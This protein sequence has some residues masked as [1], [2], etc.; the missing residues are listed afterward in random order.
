MPQ[1]NGVWTLSAAAQAQTTQQWVTDPNFKN[2]TLL[3]QADNASNAAQNNTFLDFSNNSFPIT[4]FGNAT[5]GTFTPFV[6][7]SGYWSNFF[8]GS[9]TSL[10]MAANS[11]FD[12]NA[13]SFSIE[14]WVY[15]AAIQ[16]TTGLYIYGA[17]S[18]VGLLMLAYGYTTG[19]FKI[20]QG[21]GGGI[22][23]TSANNYPANAW[24]HVA[25]TY[26]GS[27]LKLFINGVLQ[28]SAANAALSARIAGP[29]VAI[30][31]FGASSYFNGYVSNFRIC[32]AAIPTEY[33]TA[34]TTVGTVVFRPST[35]PLTTTSQGASNV[36]FLTCQ[37]RRFIDNSSSQIAIT[38]NG[39]P[40]IQAFG[41]FAPQ[42]QWTPAVIGGS[43]YFDYSG[44]SY[45]RV[46]ASA[47]SYYSA[48]GDW[49]WEAWVYP[50]SFNGP[51]YSCGILHSALESVMLRALPNGTANSTNL[52]MYAINAAGAAIIGASGTSGGTLRIN[53]WAHVVLQ[54]RSGQFDMFLNG[55]R[56]ANNNTQTTQSLRTTDTFLQIGAGIGGT[57]PFWNGYISGVRLQNGT[58]AYPNTTYTIPTAPPNPTGAAVCVNF[59]NAGI[60]DGTMNNVLQ[61]V[62]NAQVSTSVVK[63]GSNSMLFDGTDD[64]VS[65]PS[66][67]SLDLGSGDFTIECWAFNNN[68]DT[69][70]NQLFER[71]RFTVGK[72]YRAWMKPGQIVFEVNLSG[73]AT[74]AYTT[75][76]ATIKNN[77]FQWYHLAFVRNGSNFS[78][79][80]DG[81]QVATATSTAAVF[82]TTEALSVGG[83]ADGNN[84]IMMM[85]YIDD[86]RIT[87]GVARYFGTSFTPPQ[88][89]LPRQ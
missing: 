8:S 59:T 53:E 30:G 41:V 19:Q 43:G 61:T 24:Y 36:T 84:N 17:Q 65:I 70:Q 74:G 15:P 55:T 77:V 45:I 34:S 60:Y 72:S 5:Q 2:T 12:Q 88:V 79:Y 68:W 50:L 21:A 71:G 49:T 51:Q 35:A 40:S 22:R 69:D 28:G 3:L 48:L 80:R 66:S 4:R 26:D 7:T 52:N 25:Y 78:I 29:A 1:Y 87:R 14:C 42:Y 56:V 31:E 33:Q 58:A 83:A 81:V 57:N 62:G 76:T 6:E 54:R 86:F 85:G 63:Y 13:G 11:A 44:A 89:A 39:S 23:I 16:A 10:R 75:I 82:T 37:D 64:R 18:N 38:I 47:T 46:T 20:D 32:R 9:A 73:T 67:P 27:T